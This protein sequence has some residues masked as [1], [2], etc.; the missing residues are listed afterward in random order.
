MELRVLKYFL[1]IADEQNI[2]RAADMIHITQPTLSRQIMELED[3]LGVKLFERNRQNRKF[4][5]TDE[6]TR[7]YNYASQIVQLS[8]KTLADFK[9]NKSEVFGKIYIGAGETKSFTAVAEAFKK[10]KALHPKVE[11]HIFS[12]DAAVISERLDRGLCDFAVFIGF[13]N[14]EKYN[15]LP[16][17]RKDRWG[18]ITHKDNPLAKNRTIRRENLL[19]HFEPVMLS[20]QA[21]SKKELLEW[22]GGSTEKYNISG[23]YNLIYNASILIRTGVC[24]TISFDE[25]ADTSKESGL[26]FIPLEP[27]VESEAVL[28]WRKDFRLSKQA[29]LLLDAIRESLPLKDDSTSSGL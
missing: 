8:D 22:F 23:S 7:F 27:P 10:I 25:I 28:A 9:N 4:L 21:L 11:L 18:L 2:S 15:I 24:S 26:C 29:Q 20:Q 19:E 3:E 17:P 6:G 13:K 16:L 12:G 14:I 5:L 1:T